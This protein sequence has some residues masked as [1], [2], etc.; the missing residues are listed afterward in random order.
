V[1]PC[2]KY[3][4]PPPT[5]GWMWYNNY[6]TKYRC[7]DG[8]EF[9]SGSFPYWYSNCTVLKVWDPPQADTCKRK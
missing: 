1:L 8:F 3:P 7:P 4:P 9:S 2:K 6:N 5:G